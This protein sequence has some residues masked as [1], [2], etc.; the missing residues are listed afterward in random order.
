MAEKAGKWLDRL[1]T[2][3]NDPVDWDS[4]KDAFKKQFTVLDDET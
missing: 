4:F 2:M 1:T 3:G